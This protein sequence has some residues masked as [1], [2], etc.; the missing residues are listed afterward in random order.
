M[1]AD[2]FTITKL[3]GLARSVGDLL[4]IIARPEAKKVLLRVLAMSEPL[5]TGTAIG[6]LMLT[7]VGAV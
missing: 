6:R 3:D 7:V 4:E 5:D 2:T 1:E